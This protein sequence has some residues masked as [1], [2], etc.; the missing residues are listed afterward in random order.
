M[1]ICQPFDVNKNGDLLG[2]G[3]ALV[4]M[5]GA[6]S[7]PFGLG[8]GQGHGDADDSNAGPED[9]IDIKE[10]VPEGSAVDGE[11]DEGMHG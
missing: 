5:F 2:G 9:H 11:E 3:L 4:A 10:F 8:N 1:W 7:A 6:G